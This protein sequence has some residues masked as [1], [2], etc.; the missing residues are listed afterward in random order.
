MLTESRLRSAVRSVS[1]PSVPDFVGNRSRNPSSVARTSSGVGSDDMR[2][3]FIACARRPL[4]ERPEPCP[5]IAPRQPA[6]GAG[7]PGVIADPVGV[8]QLVDLAR[9]EH[10]PI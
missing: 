3:P 1:G 2:E 9:A 6:G 5:Q 10:G 4:E 8:A 7:Y